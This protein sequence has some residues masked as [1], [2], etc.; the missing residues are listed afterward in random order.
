MQNVRIVVSNAIGQSA[1]PAI[2]VKISDSRLQLDT[3]ILNSGVR[4]P[5]QASGVIRIRLRLTT[6]DVVDLT[7]SAVCIETTADARYIEEL[8]AD[9]RPQDP[10]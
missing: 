4:L 8:P 1:V 9:L 7:G 5:L 2:P 10:G 6:A 3:V